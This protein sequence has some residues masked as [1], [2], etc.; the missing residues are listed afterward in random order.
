MN[1][2]IIGGDAAGMSA[3]MQ[4]VRNDPEAR[5]TVFEKGGI[6]SYGQCGLPYVISGLI[7]S[8]ELLVARDVATFR[9]KYGM[10]ARTF[11]EVAGVDPTEKKIYGVHTKTKEEFTFSYD[12]LLIATG[13]SPVLPP[14][15]GRHLPGV[16][17]VKTIPDVE[18]II[19][20][21]DASI[22]DVTIIGG[23]YIGLEVAENLKFLGKKVRIIQRGNQLGS[24][25][26][27]DM[28]ELIL[29]EAKKHNIEVCLNEEVQRL[30]G[31]DRVQFV[32]TDKRD[33]PT[34][35]V[36]VAAGVKPNVSMIQNTEVRLHES[37]AILVNRY[38]ETNVKDIYAAG[39]CASHY[40]LIKEVDDHIPLG[41]TANKQGRIAGLNM[42]GKR[43][44][45]KGIVGSSIIKFMELSLGKT[46]ISVKEAEKLRFPVDTVTTQAKDIAG[47]FPGVEPLQ[48]KL[49]FDANNQRLLGGQFIGKYGVDKRVD[50]LATAI[51]HGMDLHELE[52]LD[53]CYAPPYNGVWD[54][55]QQAARRAKK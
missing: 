21:M 13:V 37:G 36:I 30:K 49:V 54:P 23:G 25:F 15:E 3:A 45:F 35:M 33:Y 41:T 10:D 8:S 42:A 19:K 12:K 6:Y 26:D 43:K 4:I 24:I 22:Q 29:E 20:D 32:K 48:V 17:V 52:D 27:P 50:V 34:D 5:I 46:G 11:H 28:A 2:C 40:H 51:Y 53:L 47:Y 14:W 44:T 1:Y 55:I 7:P 16:H 18:G 9:E 39:D 38:M 31:D